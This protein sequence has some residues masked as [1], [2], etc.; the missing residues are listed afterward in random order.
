MADYK[1]KHEDTPWT[2]V[3][4]IPMDNQQELQTESANLEHDDIWWKT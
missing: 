3:D 1:P 2:V 4:A